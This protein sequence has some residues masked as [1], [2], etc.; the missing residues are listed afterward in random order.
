MGHPHDMTVMGGDFD[1][2]GMARCLYIS[3]PR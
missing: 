2:N 3:V 1:D